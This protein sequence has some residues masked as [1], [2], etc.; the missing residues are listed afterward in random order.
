MGPAERAHDYRAGRSQRAGRQRA[1]LVRHRQ[2]RRRCSIS[3]PASRTSSSTCFSR[4]RRRARRTRSRKAVQDVGGYINAYTSFDRTVYWID[5]PKAGVR[6]RARYSCRRDD[7]F[8]A[9]AGGIREG[10]GSH[11]ARVR[12]GLRR[13]R[14]DGGPAAFRDG[15][16]AASL[17][18]AG[19]RPARCFQPAHAGAGDAATTRR[20][21]CRTT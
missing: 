7:E 21:T 18:A 14:P 2:H 13:S 4:A 17:P 12:D 20:A 1:G 16:S 9:A 15:L 6:D 19:D 3:A 5:I 11:P 8:D 10:T